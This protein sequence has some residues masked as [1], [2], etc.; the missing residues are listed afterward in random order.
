M[1]INRVIITGNLTR[2]PELKSLPS[3]TSVCDLGV[4]VNGRYKANDG[5]WK[6]R[7]NFFDVTVFG[8]Q[9]DACGRYLS[10]GRPVA[11]DGELRYESWEKD[12]Q[13]RS[14]VKIVAS[15]VQFLGDGS[16]RQGGSNGASDVTSDGDFAP[17]TAP[18]ADGDF[19]P[20]GAAKPADDDIPF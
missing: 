16:G 10:K 9:A 3:G 1:N 19:A 18:A 15:T 8:G 12:G 4:A 14:K 6:D 11:V 5:E 13:K 2:D 7:A 17:A 20:A